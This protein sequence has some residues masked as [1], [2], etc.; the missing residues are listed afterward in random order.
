[1]HVYRLV[2]E[3]LEL[4][5]P[6]RNELV[7]QDGWLFARPLPADLF[8]ALDLAP[9]VCLPRPSGFERALYVGE[10]SPEAAI[11]EVSEAKVAV[12]VGGL[13]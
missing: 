11:V 9:R 3:A 10:S 5:E 8:R 13:V 12:E 6:D 1:M 4:W 2:R 7:S